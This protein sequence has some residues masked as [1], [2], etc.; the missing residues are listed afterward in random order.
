MSFGIPT[1]KPG[2]LSPTYTAQPREIFYGNTEKVTFLPVP[3]TID[4]TASGNASNAP[5][6]WLLFAGTLM[7]QETTNR[8]L[9]NSIIGLS[10][11]ALGD[12]QTTL[13]TDVNT[14]AEI[15]RRIGTS[16]TLTLTGPQVASGPASGVRTLPVTFSAVNTT[17]GAIT[18]TATGTGAVSGVNQI[19][20]VVTVDSSGSGTFTITV[21]GVTTP[22]ITYSATIATL[23]TNINAQLNATFGTSA[24]VASGGSLAALVLTSS[25]TGYTNRPVGLMQVTLLTGATGFTMN[26]SGTV[27]TPSTS[28]VTT[29]GV[30]PVTASGGEFI[31]GSLIGANDG[32]TVIKTVICDKYGVKVVDQLNT[33]RVD[34]FDPQLWAG[35]GCLNSKII[36]NYP[37][38]T[39]IQAYI[40]AALRAFMGQAM[41]SD[42]FI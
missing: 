29:A 6:S 5:Y 41:F 32:S 1:G 18:I 31:T 3:V 36:V 37:T 2:M 15:V 12:A 42:D 17:T 14:A 19:N 30:V 26:G 24:I 27:G 33:T 39:G 10:S 9:A 8:K 35:G 7:G 28:P 34:V 11:A 13:S 40:K 38:D 16:G 20:S 23:I 22:A 4:G 21:E 25:G